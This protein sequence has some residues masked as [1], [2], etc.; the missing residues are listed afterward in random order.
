MLKRLVLLTGL[1][2]G[3]SP[4]HVIADE[5]E[6][7]DEEHQNKPDGTYSAEVTT[8]SGTYT[9]SVEVSG[10]EVEC[11]HWPNGGCM[12]LSGADLDSHGNAS[13]TNSQGDSVEV[14]L[15]E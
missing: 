11:V 14:Q 12:S 1:F 8:Q 13:G 15:E 2:V 6:T 10:G 5:Y 9:V 3:F 4:L 7:T